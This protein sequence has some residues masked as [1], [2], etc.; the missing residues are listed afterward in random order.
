[1]KWIAEYFLAAWALQD[2]SRC[3][4]RSFLPSLP[5]NAGVPAATK[6]AA[7]TIAVRPFMCVSSVSPATHLI[8]T[9]VIGSINDLNKLTECLVIPGRAEDGNPESI[10]PV[11]RQ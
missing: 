2:A 11:V 1:M 10:T 8:Q 9:S 6:A 7:S 4:R 5:A 3:A